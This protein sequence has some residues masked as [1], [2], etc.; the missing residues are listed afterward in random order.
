MTDKVAAAISRYS[1]IKPNDSVCVAVSGGCDSVALLGALLELKDSLHISL[2][3]VHVNHNLRGAESDRDEAYVRKLCG[4]L[5]VELE[6][7]SVDVRA[8]CE[9]SG[10]SVELAARRLRYECFEKIAGAES[11][12][13]A[14]KSAARE[15]TAREST[16]R[17]STARNSAA[18]TGA[19]AESPSAAEKSAARE[20]TA[21][22]SA[23]D[24]GARALIATAHT[25][26]D[27]TET[28]LLNL[29]RGSG[30]RG[31]CGI[32][33]VRGNLIRPLIGCTRADTERYCAEHGLTYVTDS[34]NFVD[35]CSRN[36]VRLNVVPL[37]RQLNPALDDAVARM[38][39]DLS[40]I[41]SMLTRMAED[42][43]ER[44]FDGEVYLTDGLLMN[45]YPV[46]TRALRLLAER[47]TG[48]APDSLHT[49]QLCLKVASCGRVQLSGGWFAECGR[50]IRFVK[51]ADCAEKP[52]FEHA[53]EAGEIDTPEFLLKIFTSTDS[54]SQSVNNFSISHTLDCDKISGKAVIRTRREGDFLRLKGR[55]L[56][57]L[58]KLMN[59]LH[60][61]SEKRDLYPIIADESGVICA[62]G[63]GV[64][65]RVS[66]DNGSK[67]L[68]IINAEGK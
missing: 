20:S 47:K 40:D 55:P 35:D 24:T 36:F 34:T 26:S 30:V 33:P 28:V 13:A 16:A 19:G 27:S 31:L 52:S 53:F 12:S 60:I 22:N 6:V 29:T 67:N 38:S 62:V 23:A 61:P 48:I 41:D 50:G 44:S 1:M 18:D 15:S 14:E 21:C 57:P 65:E 54:N 4:E 45:E 43:L 10:D 56:K 11:P 37:L 17:E 2:C 64:D 39:A 9:K 49:E 68:I 3:A 5:G 7:F 8:E 42:A 25:M 63:I 59:E 58:R 66:A 51:A 32:P 46:L